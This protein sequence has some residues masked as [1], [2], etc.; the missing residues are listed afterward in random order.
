MARVVLDTSVLVAIDRDPAVIDTLL[1]PECEYFLPEIVVAE[2]LVG[3]ELAQSTEEKANKLAKLHAFEKL[4]S[5]VNFGRAEARAYAFFAAAAKRSGTP[6][7]NFDLAIAASAFV[8]DAKLQTSD[9][10]AKFEE[11]P[12]VTVSYF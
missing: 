4:V 7:T 2:F 12:G 10:A 6:R 11:L 8:L 5:L 3:V 9:R 1:R